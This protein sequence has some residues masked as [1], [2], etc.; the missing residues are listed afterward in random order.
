MRHVPNEARQLAH[1]ELV[2]DED[3]SEKNGVSS[4]FSA[5]VGGGPLRRKNNAIEIQHATGV[6]FI[7]A[8]VADSD[9]KKRTAL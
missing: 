6:R 7:H 3:G 5:G 9:L 1:F 8:T 4:G 2:V